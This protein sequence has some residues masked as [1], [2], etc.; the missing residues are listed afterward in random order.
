MPTDTAPTALAPPGRL[1]SLDAPPGA[2]AGTVTIINLHLAP[3]ILLVLRDGGI[4][5]RN[6][7]R[8]YRIGWDQVRCFTDASSWNMGPFW[9]LGIELR[10]GRK[11]KAPATRNWPEAEG[12]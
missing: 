7:L 12:P 11:V 3:W 6:V 4:T 2:P 1:A 8:T 5:A 9:E 10:N